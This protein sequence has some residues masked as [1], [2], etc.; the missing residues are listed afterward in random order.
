MR[1]R[2]SAGHSPAIRQHEFYQFNRRGLLRNAEIGGLIG[3]TYR[4]TLNH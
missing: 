2:A 1:A 4:L 3:C